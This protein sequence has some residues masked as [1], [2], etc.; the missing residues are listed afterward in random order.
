MPKRKKKKQTHKN[1]TAQTSNHRKQQKM[2][3]RLSKNQLSLK[4]STISFSSVERVLLVHVKK[5][6]GD[7]QK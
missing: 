4:L 1:N 6:I 2:R 3:E 7:Y 5:K